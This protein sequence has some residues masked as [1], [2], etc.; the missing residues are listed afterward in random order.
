M[1]VVTT[2]MGSNKVVNRATGRRDMVSKNQADTVEEENDVITNNRADHTM[3]LMEV[4]VKITEGDSS[5][6]VEDQGRA[7]E[8]TSTPT[9]LHNT[10]S[11]MAAATAACFRPRCP[12]WVVVRAASTT[13]PMSM[14]HS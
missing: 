12:S 8:V 9:R 3:T 2:V 4:E 5:K 1:S 7:L 6:R 10:P 11:S 13:F 14:S